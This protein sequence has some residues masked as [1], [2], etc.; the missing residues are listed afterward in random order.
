MDEATSSVDSSTDQQVQDTIQSQF[1]NNGVT[2][3]TV[4]HRLDTIM[5]YDKVAILGDGELL[6][7]GIPRELASL[8]SGEF[9]RLIDAD[10]QKKMRGAKDVEE[11]LVV[12]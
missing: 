1:V 6:E 8:P 11:D 10:R 9:K 2:V 12:M 4:A 7:Y 3:I 5:N